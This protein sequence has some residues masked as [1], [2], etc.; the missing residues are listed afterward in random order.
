MDGDGHGDDT[1]W[2]GAGEGML[3]L[4][5]DGN[6]TVSNGGEFSFI[7]DIKG[8]TSDLAGLRAFDS[9]GDGALSSA[10]GRFA[11]FRIWRDRNGD[12]VA[13]QGEIL[14]LADAGVQSLGLAGAAV[15]GTAA[16]GD[17]VTINKGSFTRTDGTSAEFLDA[18][19]TYFSGTFQN[20]IS[21]PIRQHVSPF[22]RR[23]MDAFDRDGLRG[24]MYRELQA[25]WQYERDPIAHWPQFGDQRM[26]SGPAVVAIDY[27]GQFVNLPNSAPSVAP[28]IDRQLAMMVQEMSVFGA[29]SA[30]EGLGTWQRENTRPL[31]FFA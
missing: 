15:D 10:D 1:S 8:A 30:D 5:R 11:E 14:S 3:F 26:W 4:D 25:D 17:V 24:A 27:L 12:G 2:M 29:R 18:A 13:D 31:D 19:F 28:G 21:S 9:N 7:N 6:G 20:G 16:L 23:Q 22:S